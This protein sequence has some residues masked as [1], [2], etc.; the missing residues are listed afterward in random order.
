MRLFWLE[1]TQYTVYCIIP[2]VPRSWWLE[3]I[4]DCYT[5]RLILHTR[6]WDFEWRRRRRWQPDFLRKR[7]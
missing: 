4:L 6:P 2:A 1:R 5:L 7:R 3:F